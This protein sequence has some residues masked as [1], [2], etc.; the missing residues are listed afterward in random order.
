MR[1]TRVALLCGALAASFSGTLAAHAA[2]P[3][4]QAAAEVLF[5]EARKLVA[6]GNHAQACPKFAESQRLDPTAGGALSVADCFEKIGKLASAWGAFKQ[7]E[8]ISRDSGDS[9]RQAEAAKR[10][11]AL[12]PRLAKLVITV[13]PPARAPGLEVKRDGSVVGE[14]QWGS[15]MPADK[16]EHI[17]E[18]SAP[19]RKA[20]STVARV[21]ADGGSVSVDIPELAAATSETSASTGAGGSKQKTAGF[22]VG[23]VGAAGLVVGAVIGGLSLKKMNDAK[24]NGRCDADLATCDATGLALHDDAKSLAHGST[25]AFVVGGALLA[26]GVVLILTSPKAADTTAPAGGLQVRLGGVAGA[27]MTGVLLS[28]RW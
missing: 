13:P 1:T 11:E 12:A 28:G 24:A 10:A 8:M 6:A 7:A 9:A 15:A 3:A 18:V 14:G 2:S 20:W 23:G 4:D 19:G 5:N 16:G 27:A 22:V 21:E 26:T 17:I 25:A